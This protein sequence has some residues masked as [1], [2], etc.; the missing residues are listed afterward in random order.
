MSTSKQDQGISLNPFFKDRFL[1]TPPQIHKQRVKCYCAKCGAPVSKSGM[2][3]CE[4]CI[5][6]QS[7]IDGYTD[8]E[9]D[10][11]VLAIWNLHY[12]KMHVHRLLSQYKGISIPQEVMRSLKQL[13]TQ[14]IVL[15]DSLEVLKQDS[16]LYLFLLI[17]ACET[18]LMLKSI[19]KESGCHEI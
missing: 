15:I 7:L 11:L 2:V 9:Y 10:E 16:Q 3:I 12:A 5:S 13:R 18:K 6:L 8:D 4:A 14:L 19:N 17:I 1:K